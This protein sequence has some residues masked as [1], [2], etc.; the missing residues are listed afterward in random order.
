MYPMV[1]T[2]RIPKTTTKTNFLM[3]LPLMIRKNTIEIISMIVA[4]PK[5]QRSPHTKKNAAVLIP[6]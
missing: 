6:F 2:V 1:M 3:N 5:K 4:V